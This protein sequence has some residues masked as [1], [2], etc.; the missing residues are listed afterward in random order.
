MKKT[1]SRT[2]A[3]A[4]Q[5]QTTLKSHIATYDKTCVGK[6]VNTASLA[7]RSYKCIA[8]IGEVCTKDATVIGR[9]W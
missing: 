4:S 8:G 1:A 9:I 3:K 5:P 2:N 7:G 6:W